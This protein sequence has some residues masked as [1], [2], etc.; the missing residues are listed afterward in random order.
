MPLLP[1]LLLAF[2]LLI[3]LAAVGW[4]TWLGAVALFSVSGQSC[5]YGLANWTELYLYAWN[6]VLIL[7]AF[8]PP[9][10]LSLSTKWSNSLIALG[11]CALANAGVF[12]LWFPLTSWFGLCN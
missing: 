10:A 1:R 5:T 9:L 7:G 8:I 11:V 12:L 6:G 3:A 4:F 2:V